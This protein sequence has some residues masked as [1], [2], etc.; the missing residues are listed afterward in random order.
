H[1]RDRI[2]KAKT[3]GLR[4]LLLGDDPDP[5][6]S[7]LVAEMISQHW[8]ETVALFR[9]ALDRY[10]RVQAL[11]VA[12]GTPVL[13]I[14]GEKDRLVPAAHAQALAGSVRNGT[15]VTLP[16]LGHMLRLAGA[17]EIIPRIGGRGTG[18]LR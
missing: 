10:D 14:V 3:I 15:A 11:S 2:D 5:A 17:A 9:P 4:W 8:P 7:R 18:I 1:V 13:A 6:D 12:A 16:A